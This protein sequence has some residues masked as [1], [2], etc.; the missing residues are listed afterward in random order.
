MGGSFY[1]RLACQRAEF[2]GRFYRL[3]V[4]PD[5]AALSRTGRRQL[6]I[7]IIVPVVSTFHVLAISG[8]YVVFWYIP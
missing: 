8:S 5:C 7:A 3:V 1:R 2:Q 6:L 4:A